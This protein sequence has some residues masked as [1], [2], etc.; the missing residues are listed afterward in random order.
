[1][2]DLEI[3]ELWIKDDYPEVSVGR[4]GQH[5][6]VMAAGFRIVWF[7]AHNGT[8]GCTWINNESA[9]NQMTVNLRDPESIT[10]LKRVMDQALCKDMPIW[11]CTRE[12]IG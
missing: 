2:T 10:Q 1:M 11:V 12:D 7:H 9:D 6:D 5:L 3:L 4:F 8:I